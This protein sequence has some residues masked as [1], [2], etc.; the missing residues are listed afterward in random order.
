MQYA[1]KWV[2]RCILP[3]A[4]ASPRP[5]NPAPLPQLSWTSGLRTL[6]HTDQAAGT[7][8]ARQNTDLQRKIFTA[9]YFPAPSV[10][11]AGCSPQISVT[12]ESARPAES[13]PKHRPPTNPDKE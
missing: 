3:G 1:R 10:P 8:H 9:P 7:R 13:A 4:G 6:V 5:R 11:P 12:A 2:G